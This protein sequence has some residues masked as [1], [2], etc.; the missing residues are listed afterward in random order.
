MG[1]TK[2]AQFPSK[3]LQ[4]CPKKNQEKFTDEL[5]YVHRENISGLWMGVWASAKNSQENTFVVLSCSG[6]EGFNDFGIDSVGTLMQI[7]VA[8]NFPAMVK[9][10]IGCLWL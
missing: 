6:R 3:F 5:L 10:K 4:D 2:L 7:W 8:G 1:L 9:P